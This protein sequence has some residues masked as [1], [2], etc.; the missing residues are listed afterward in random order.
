[1]NKEFLP[2]YGDWIFRALIFLGIYAGLAL[3]SRYV[4]REEFE[5]FRQ[6]VLKQQ[7]T[8]EVM[9]EQNKTN[10]RQD[11]KIADLESRMRVL[12]RGLLRS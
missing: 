6:L 10:D 9:V 2:K 5:Q 8:L 12:E 4:T 3:N 7:T 11:A 1:M